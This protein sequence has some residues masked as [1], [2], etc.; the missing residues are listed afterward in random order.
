MQQYWQTGFLFHFYIRT[1]IS[2]IAY[3]VITYK[4]GKNYSLKDCDSIN[5]TELSECV[6]ALNNL[7]PL[8]FAGDVDGFAAVDWCKEDELGGVDPDSNLTL[9]L[10][11]SPIVVLVICSFFGLPEFCVGWVDISPFFISTSAFVFFLLGNV[12]KLSSGGGNT[13]SHAPSNDGEVA[14]DGG[15]SSWVKDCSIPLKHEKY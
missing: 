4:F 9:R 3:I 12:Y 6:V 14:D 5:H 2:C 8:I 13:I 7:L 11:A 1:F 15:G 10:L